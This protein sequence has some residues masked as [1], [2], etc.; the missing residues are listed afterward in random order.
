MGVF[1]DGDY[2]LTRVKHADG[3]F[4]QVKKGRDVWATVDTP[5]RDTTARALSVAY[6]LAAEDRTTNVVVDGLD[7]STLYSGDQLTAYVCNRGRPIALVNAEFLPL[8]GRIL[9]SDPAGNY[10]P[11]RRLVVRTGQVM[12]KH[13]TYLIRERAARREVAFRRVVTLAGDAMVLKLLTTEPDKS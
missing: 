9:R 7:V 4:V 11:I 6:Q 3:L 1:T 10:E 8:T 2:T 13:H 12:L 5:D